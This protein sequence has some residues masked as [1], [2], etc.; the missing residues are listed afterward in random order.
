MQNNNQNQIAAALLIAG[1]MISGAILL[2]DSQPPSGE[3]SDAN[4]NG[5]ISVEMSPINK[6]DHIV[7]NPNAKIIIVEY[8]DLDCPY[9]KVFH[10]TMQQ[11][12]ASNQNVAWVYRHYPIPALHPDAFKKAEATECAWEQGGNDAFWAYTD[13]LF[14]ETYSLSELPNLAQSLGLNVNTFN[15]CLSSGKYAAKI[16]ADIDG[17]NLAGVSGTPSSFI[18]VDGKVVDTIP[19][20]Q[21]LNIVNERLKEIR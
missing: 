9:C 20:A 8:S 3:P 11:V 10:Q 13:K 19:G 6:D 5:N 4:N 21:P 2:K 18:V 12:V 17:G 1:V 15:T 16:Q 14:E 7:G